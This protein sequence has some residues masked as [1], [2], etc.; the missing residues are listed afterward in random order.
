MKPGSD[1]D[2]TIPPALVAEVRA[3]ADEEHRPVDDV[4]RD[5]VEQALGE[6]RWKGQPRQ[7]AAKLSA[8]EAV[9]R[10]LEQRKGNVLP[11]GVTIRDLMTY[12]RA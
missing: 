4:L 11:D 2:L 9:E 7:T 6:R 12:G 5:L 1:T 8:A 3:I 10:L